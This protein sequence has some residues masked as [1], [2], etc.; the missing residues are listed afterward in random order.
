[1]LTTSLGNSRLIY[2]FIFLASEIN[3][4]LGSFHVKSTQVVTSLTLILITFAPHIIT[5]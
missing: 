5:Q 3:L 4:T 1:M 2:Y